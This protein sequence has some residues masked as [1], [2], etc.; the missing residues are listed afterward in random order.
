MNE[1]D[2]TPRQ[3]REDALMWSRAGYPEVA[4]GRYRD[5][6]YQIQGLHDLLRLIQT[7]RGNWLHS[8]LQAQIEAVVGPPGPYRPD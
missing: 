7:D 3:M 1:F 5:A 6:S 8:D 4:V 2:R